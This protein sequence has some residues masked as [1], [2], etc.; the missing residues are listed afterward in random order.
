MMQA[1]AAPDYFE[2]APCGLV[3]TDASGLFLKVNKTFCDWVGFSSAQLVGVKRFQDLLAMGG[4]IFHQTH[5]S[6]LLQMQG[7]LSEVKLEFITQSGESLPMVFNAIRRKRGEQI[8]HEIATFV[9]NDRD[10]YERELVSARKTLELLVA[11]TAQLHAESRDRALLA[12]QMM[13]IVSHD[14]RNPLNTVHVSSTLLKRGVLTDSQLKV[15]NRIQRSA[16]NASRLIVDLLDFTQAKLGKGIS[17]SMRT[18]DLH[19]TIAEA[20]GDIGGAYPQH[21]FTHIRLGEGECFADPN[22]LAQL[23]GNLLTNAVTYGAAD[24]PV[25]VT[26]RIGD[27]NFELAVH[28]AGK[29]IPEELIHSIFQPMTRG[30]ESN[31]GTRSVGLGLFIVSEIAKAHNGRVSVVSSMDAGTTFTAHFPRRADSPGLAP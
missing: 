6:P 16:D 17:V 22:R 25:T 2:E 1:G 5:W 3:H 29:A 11:E 20:I 13:G 12:E 10:K 19:A 28:N 9:A 15:V 26:S 8:V 23:L 14:L 24:Q 31:G 7:S 18:M 27:K 4:R 30:E 21:V